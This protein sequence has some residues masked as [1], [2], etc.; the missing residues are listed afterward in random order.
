MYSNVVRYSRDV[1]GTCS[2]ELGDKQART[3]QSGEMM[4]RGSPKPPR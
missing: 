4:D 1:P 2:W 3:D